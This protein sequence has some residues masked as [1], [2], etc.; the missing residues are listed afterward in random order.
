MVICVSMFVLMLCV[1]VCS[2]MCGDVCVVICVVM[3]V[4]MCAV[5][6]VVVL[7]GE[8]CIPGEVAGGDPGSGQSGERDTGQA[9]FFCQCQCHCPLA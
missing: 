3:C 2:D 4:L 1:D 5:M 9:T 7:P 8:R 6:C